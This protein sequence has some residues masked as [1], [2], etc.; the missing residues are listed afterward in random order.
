MG[1]DLNFFFLPNISGHVITLDQGSPNLILEGRCP[2]EFSSNLDQHTCLEFSSI[3]KYL[4]SWFRCVWLG[5]QLNSAGHR[6][7]RTEPG[8]PYSRWCNWG[9]GIY[10]RKTNKQIYEIFIV[11]IKLKTIHNLSLSQKKGTKWSLGRYTEL[12]KLKGFVLYLPQW[13][14]CNF[15]SES[16]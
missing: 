6:P 9:N 16:V 15:F 3:R 7:S 11:I 14:F 4:I 12:Q 2:V 1:I 5:L 8:D 10:K 13:Q